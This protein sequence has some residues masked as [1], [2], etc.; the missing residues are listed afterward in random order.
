M[1][2]MGHL[3]LPDQMQN[4]SR[5]NE[6]SVFVAALLHHTGVG[7]HA[8]HRPQ[9][10]RGWPL[11]L[12]IELHVWH[13]DGARCRR[14]PL[15]ARC[16]TRAEVAPRGDPAWALIVE[17]ILNVVFVDLAAI[18]VADPVRRFNT[19]LVRWNWSLPLRDM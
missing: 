5:N 18:V 8:C 14:D 15:R 13:E 6:R 9:K 4:I 2:L 11:N 12:A 17:A 16:A 10:E 3:P 19:R 7:S 1:H